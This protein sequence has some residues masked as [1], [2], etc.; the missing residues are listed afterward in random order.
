M[1][2][3]WYKDAVI[4][5]VHVR[6]FFDANGDG[7]GD[8][9]GV[10]AKLPYIE[11]LGVNTLWLLP[12]YQS[13]LR[14]DGYDISDYTTILPI[15]GT[16][17]D[18][19]ALLT[20]AHERGLRVITE[21]VL[22]HTSDRHAW[23]QEA[24][25]PGSPKRDWY[26]WSDTPE[27][28]KDVR[29]IFT[30]TEYSNWAWDPVAK[31]YYWHRFFSHQPDLN[32]DNPEVEKA[33]H[34]VMFY[35]LDMGVDGLRL[36]AIPYL[37]EREG[38]SGENLPETLA[39]IKR[40]RRAID[41]RY[42]PGKI[43]LAEANQ[44]PEDTLPY[45]GDGD[46]VQMAFNFPVMPRMYL[47]LRRENR[48]PI[49]E[50][51]ELTADIPESAQWAL[52]LRNH[53]ELTLE[54]VTDEERD[55]LYNEYAADRQYRLNL[56]IRRRLSPLLGGERRRIELMNGL[57]LSLK[58]SP[59]LYYGDEI[60][61]G[62]N[63]FLGDRNGVRTPMQWSRD[64][65]AGF[66][67]APFHRLFL[68]PINEGRYSYQFVNVEEEEADPHSLYHFT[69]RLLAVRN[70][71][72]EVFGKGRLELLGLDNPRVFAYL[73]S[74]Q[75]KTI[76]VVANLSRFAQAVELP[77]T[78]YRHY[79]LIELFSYAPFPTIDHKHY[80]LTLGPHGF[81]WF[82]LQSPEEEA[83]R[84][85]ALKPASPP[86]ETQPLPSLT[87][88]GGLET[89]LV[90]TMLEGAARD[91]L[92]QLLPNYLASQ[93]WFGGK[94]Q[95]LRAVHLTDAVR[96]QAQPLASYLCLLHVSYH[97]GEAERYLL[98]LAAARGEA[99]ERLLRER[100]QAAIA[101][102]QSPSGEL[103]LHDATGNPEFWSALYQA[104]RR[105]WRGRSLQGLYRAETPPTATL[106]DTREV[107]LL[108]ADQSN[109][110]AVFEGAVF[111]KLY[112][113]LSEGPNPEVELLDYFQRV[114]FSFVPQVKGKVSFKRGGLELAL[115]LFQDY[116]AGEGD[117]WSIVLSDISRYLDRTAE[118]TPPEDGF[119]KGPED[120]PPA[121]LADSGGEVLQLAQRLGVRTAELHLAL[122]QAKEPALIPEPTEPAEL[123]T[124]A[125]RVRSEARRTQRLLE[126]LEPQML[127]RGLKVLTGLSGA[128]WNKIRIHGDYHLGQVL[129][130]EGELYILD[131]EGEP[132]RSLEERRHKD[133]ALKD[134]AG[135][136]RSLE[137]AVLVA[138]RGYEHFGGNGNLELWADLLIRWSQTIFLE[139]YLTTARQQGASFLPPEPA[140]LAQLL[141]AYQF[142]KALYEARYE[143]G[144]RPEWLELPLRGLRRLLNALPE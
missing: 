102:L 59:V 37:Y 92:E 107:K 129:Q 39:A 71:H 27:K 46:G 6:S 9:A 77:L 57:L 94:E 34:E 133:Q 74:Y 106:P 35:W 45:F 51:L 120:T 108:S 17:E 127:Q 15:H 29:I 143:L 113:K 140:T 100:P 72:A 125:R 19:R 139:A 79:R 69:R 124:L 138:W 5:Q 41:E 12:F 10:R 44:W 134:V 1:D 136:M 95:Q 117:L 26:V 112:R 114:G 58:G 23:F 67:E 123:K 76:L 115:G 47:A 14:D 32:R 43:L 101:R 18:F 122:Q 30:D 131:F 103:L 40:L 25:I 118:T 20:D 24:R 116:L 126:G 68:P 121:W 85:E 60:G 87:L 111:A 80:T 8:L 105:G 65:N 142:D 78:A 110:A 137:Y 42:G 135:M 73:R 11:A 119:P 22:N 52:F 93:R 104:T 128:G 98:P 81:Y 55:Y 82:L 75:G 2:P 70:Q 144:H 53:D 84:Q 86:P 3:L 13:P 89:L 132:D 66:S 99:A 141:W 16:L 54:M 31:A 33:L 62:D 21:L 49:T 109:S 63:I 83:G 96:L 97:G 56:G 28:Y 61:M 50:M 38:T 64:R 90:G 91:K 4:Y 130:A 36:D 48:Q 88:S 7:V